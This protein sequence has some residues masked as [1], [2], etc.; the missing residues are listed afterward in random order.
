MLNEEE[1]KHWKRENRV[2]MHTKI[3]GRVLCNDEDGEAERKNFTIE[4]G[5]KT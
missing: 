5:K 4:K 2:S 1:L 3:N